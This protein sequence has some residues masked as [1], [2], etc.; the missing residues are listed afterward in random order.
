[1]IADQLEGLLA[2]A[3]A[4]LAAAVR[5]EAELRRLLAEHRAAE[6]AAGGRAA[7]LAEAA[8]HARLAAE[9]AVARLGDVRAEHAAAARA[10]ELAAD[11]AAGGDAEAAGRLAGLRDAAATLAALVG[12]HERRWAG[13]EAEREA[14]AA[15]LAAHRAEQADRK[16]RELEALL[17]EVAAAVDQR[18]GEAIALGFL[19]L[20]DLFARRREL[21]P[22]EEWRVGW[23]QIGRDLDALRYAFDRAFAQ[24]DPGASGGLARAAPTFADRAAVVV[25]AWRH[26][27]GEPLLPAPTTSSSKAA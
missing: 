6:E 12:A 20:D 9:A 15:A 4:E 16:G 1:M 7:E 21:R 23:V 25:N 5:R 22:R 18:L 26:A 8:E 27:R 13:L 3:K 11:Q 19:A 10:L 2:T 14:A 24:R 17:L